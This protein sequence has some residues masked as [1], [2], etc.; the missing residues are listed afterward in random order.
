[1]HGIIIK[2][3]LPWTWHNENHFYLKADAF[4]HK[5][6]YKHSI[7][8][9]IIQG[10]VEVVLLHTLSWLMF[11]QN[12]VAA[13]IQVCEF[14]TKCLLWQNLHR[15]WHCNVNLPIVSK[16]SSSLLY[17]FQWVCINC[18]IAFELSG[19]LLSIHI[20]AIYYY[21]AIIYYSDLWDIRLLRNFWRCKEKF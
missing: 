18:L 3:K 12:D 9:E 15:I 10:S 8:N 14:Q 17:L 11:W 6:R 2:P 20:W 19:D 7:E 21:V 4:L 1:M 5:V 16:F 13:L